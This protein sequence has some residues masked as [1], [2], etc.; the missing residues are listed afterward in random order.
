MAIPADTVWEVRPTQTSSTGGLVIKGCTFATDPNKAY[1]Y[2]PSGTT[3]TTPSPWYGAY[4][5][6]FPSNEAELQQEI[7]SLRRENDMLKK[8]IDRDLARYRD[9]LQ[10]ADEL[11]EE[12]KMMTE[13][14]GGQ[15]RDEEEE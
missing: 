10:N 13:P 3:A 14:I 11:V 2:N 4:P 5:F 8:F 9:D 7:E 6:T 1:F 15:R 12:W